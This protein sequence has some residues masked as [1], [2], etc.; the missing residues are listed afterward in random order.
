[1]L[2]LFDVLNKLRLVH[3]AAERLGEVEKVALE[4]LGLVINGAAFL[5]DPSLDAVGRIG[6]DLEDARALGE[7]VGAVAAVASLSTVGEVDALVGPPVIVVMVVAARHPFDSL[8]FDEG[9]KETCVNRAAANG[10][11]LGTVVVEIVEE[12]FVL[13]EGDM[14][15]EEALALGWIAALD[16]VVLGAEPVDLI[17]A[18]AVPA[19]NTEA[20]LAAAIQEPQTEDDILTV[21][22]VNGEHVVESVGD[23][24]SVGQGQ[25]VLERAIELRKEGSVLDVALLIMVSTSGGPV[26]LS[27]SEW[28]G[29]VGVSGSGPALG[30]IVRPRVS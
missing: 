27:G 3:C 10:L 15:E 13:I 25:T 24:C 9:A 14:Y 5:A 21:L 17:G 1:M 26:C 6:G 16:L 8:L 28:L 29:E 30:L 4:S 2:Y 7:T 22:V 18:H 20:F 19:T 23:V 11:T 12:A